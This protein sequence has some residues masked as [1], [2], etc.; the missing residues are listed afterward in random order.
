MGSRLTQDGSTP[1]RR[2]KFA[3]RSRDIL[4][5]ILFLMTIGIAS[6][7]EVVEPGSV[8]AI[9]ATKPLVEAEQ[10][11]LLELLPFKF[12]QYSNQMCRDSCTGR[13]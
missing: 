9:E 3:P 12:G 13:D 11:V 8:L 1:N 2:R 10:D 5:L 7:M 4:T 6:A